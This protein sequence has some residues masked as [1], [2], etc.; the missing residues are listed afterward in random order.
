M[1]GPHTAKV[2]VTATFEHP[3][4]V[5]L[6]HALDTAPGFRS[7]LLAFQQFRMGCLQRFGAAF[8]L[9]LQAMPLFF[10]LPF[11][12]PFFGRQTSFFDEVAD[13]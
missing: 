5:R 9:F 13:G 10:L 12:C 3:L 2:S 7:L 8:G 6:S 4:K 11:A 1:D